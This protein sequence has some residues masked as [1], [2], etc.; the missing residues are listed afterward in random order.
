M[1][2]PP[3]PPPPSQLPQ[4]PQQPGHHAGHHMD[5][6]ATQVLPNM[7]GAGGG[8]GGFGA[9]SSG[10]HGDE[11]PKKSQLPKILGIGA[12]VVVAGS[13]GAGGMW[14]LMNNDDD[15]QQPVAQATDDTPEPSAESTAETS[16][17]EPVTSETDAADSLNQP[18]GVEVDIDEL[19]G[20]SGLDSWDGFEGFE[21][22]EGLE[23][24]EGLADLEDLLG[25]MNLEDFDFEN[26]GN[27]DGGL[28]PGDRDI[29]LRATANGEATV[30]YGTSDFDA[31]AMEEFTDSWS[32]DRT[33]VDFDTYFSLSVSPT[34][35]FGGGD[36][37]TE[38]SCELIVDGEVVDSS[39]NTGR[40]ANVHCSIFD[41]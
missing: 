36:P 24:L 38:V 28:V 11:P 34:F 17:E 5:P 6:D 29:Q 14:L 40:Y 12:A 16:S 10:F 18:D 13:L 30:T 19:L 35:S 15:D 37:A 8:Q 32:L 2:Y 21:G 9:T 3:I 20:G 7:T 23:G 27:G 33:D 22:F 25:D 41:F 1:S 4:Q 31:T 39:T 26:F